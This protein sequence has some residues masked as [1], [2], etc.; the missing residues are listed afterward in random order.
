METYIILSHDIC[1]FLFTV[2]NFCKCYPFIRPWNSP[3]QD[4]SEEVRLIFH[5]WIGLFY[6]RTT[7]RFFNVDSQFMPS[8]LESYS[9]KV[10]NEISAPVNPETI[11]TSSASFV[12]HHTSHSMEPKALN[13]SKDENAIL[14]PE[15]EILDLSVRSSSAKSGFLKPQVQRNVNSFSNKKT[16]MSRK[17][18]RSKSSV[19]LQESSISKVCTTSEFCVERQL[20][21]L[22]PTVLFAF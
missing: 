16:G 19:K 14:K 5:M 15:A 18:K 3:F 20:Q 1:L 11:I 17:F 22:T 9:L 12:N 4:T 6:S 7:A 8:C 2:A 21:A 13:L 10:A